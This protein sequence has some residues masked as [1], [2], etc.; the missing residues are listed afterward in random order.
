MIL[1]NITVG[2]SSTMEGRVLTFHFDRNQTLEFQCPL[3]VPADVAITAFR[4]F[5]NIAEEIVT[6]SVDPDIPMH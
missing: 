5:L 2:E 3:N 1:T 6:P 4:G